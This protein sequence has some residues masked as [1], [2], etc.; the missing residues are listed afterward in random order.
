MS[1]TWRH[2]YVYVPCPMYGLRRTALCH[3]LLCTLFEAGSLC[4]SPLYCMPGSR[5][6]IVP[7]SAYLYPHLSVGAQRFQKHTTFDSSRVWR[8]W[9]QVHVAPWQVFYPPRYLLF[10][11][12]KSRN[13]V[14]ITTALIKKTERKKCCL[15]CEVSGIT[16]QLVGLRNDATVTVESMVILK[17]ML[18]QCSEAPAA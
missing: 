11:N 17:Q 3:S 13:S 10:W 2:V 6:M 8:I 4:F 12:F 14:P 15:R 5:A 9:T 7:W 1:D 16:T 18:K